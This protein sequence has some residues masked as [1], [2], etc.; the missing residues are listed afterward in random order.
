MIDV[1]FGLAVEGIKKLAASEIG[2]HAMHVAVHKAI[3][4]AEKGI[5]QRNRAK[6][7]EQRSRRE[8]GNHRKNNA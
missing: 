7:E 3:H 4:S 8:N 5:E 2:H 6:A 1:L